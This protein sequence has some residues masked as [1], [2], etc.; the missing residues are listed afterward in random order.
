MHLLIQILVA[1]LGLLSQIG[2][3]LLGLL[4]QVGITFLSLQFQV[5]VAI[6]GLLLKI[7]VTG[8]NLL[9]QVGITL[10]GLLGQILIAFL[11]LL[12]QIGIT[13]LGSLEQVGIAFLDL[14]GQILLAILSLLLKIGISLGTSVHGVLIGIGT[15][16]FG[17][18]IRFVTSAVRII[19]G[20]DKNILVLTLALF[21]DFLRLSLTLIN[22]LI[23][24]LHGE[25]QH[26]GGTLSLSAGACRSTGD[27]L[28]ASGFGT[29]FHLGDLFTQL[30]LT[31]LRFLQLL[32]DLRNLRNLLTSLLQL[33][34]K[35]SNL[36]G[37]L[38]S[39]NNL[40]LRGGETTGQFLCIGTELVAFMLHGGELFAE[41][42]LTGGLSGLSGLSRKLIDLGGET[43]H[44]ILKLFVL[45]G[46]RT[47]AF[48]SF[49]KLGCSDLSGLSGLIASTGS[50][51]GGGLQRRVLLLQGLHLSVKLGNLGIQVGDIRTKSLGGLTARRRLPA[52]SLNSLGYLIEE[53]VDF[54]GIVTFLETN[55]LEDMLPNI[56]RRQQ[57]H[58]SYTSLWA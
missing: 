10:L 15:S 39:H 6:L 49:G 47:V 12:S 40:L 2:I 23:V 7:R 19:V 26:G 18:G 53:I 46:Q 28:Q 41:I 38:L 54:L 55:C 35:L 45:C 29:R 44:L 58:K 37:L 56:F 22:I 20:L 51:L 30:R 33:L 21:G 48:L 34:G 5:F 8:L 32:C 27:L 11:G 57:S 14:L 31:L 17:V 13:L 50:L 43:I 42:G 9:I 24:Q 3:T 36:C 4:I 1:I 52:K 16:V 25:G